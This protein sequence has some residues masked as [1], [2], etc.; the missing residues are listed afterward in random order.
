MKTLNVTERVVLV[1][2]IDQVIEA[3]P[4]DRTRAEKAYQ[5]L[6]RVIRGKLKTAVGR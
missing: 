6:I 5:R 1:G 2:L 3:G 4:I